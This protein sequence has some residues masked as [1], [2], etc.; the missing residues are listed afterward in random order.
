M[1]SRPA[2][3]DAPSLTSLYSPPQLLL[4]S[5]SLF[6]RLLLGHL[7]SPP[8]DVFLPSPPPSSPGP[9]SVSDPSLLPMLPGVLSPS[10]GVSSGDHV[11]LSSDTESDLSV[12]GLLKMAG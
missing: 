8:S 7:L 3:D 6:L 9:S 1:D 10:S 5:L 4:W 12:L 11:A 2:L